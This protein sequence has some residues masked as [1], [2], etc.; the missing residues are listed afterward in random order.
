MELVFK[1]QGKDGHYTDLITIYSVKLGSW[2]E[3]RGKL[4][5]DFASYPV[6]IYWNGFGKKNIHNLGCQMSIVVFGYTIWNSLRDFF[7][8]SMMVVKVKEGNWI[9]FDK[10]Y[11]R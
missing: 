1:K 5:A 11:W 9:K 4:E 2:R 6:M 7:P 3:W 10:S 8:N